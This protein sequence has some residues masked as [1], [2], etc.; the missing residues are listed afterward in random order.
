[1]KKKSTKV[2]IET[3]NPVCTKVR[4]GQMKEKKSMKVRITLIKKIHEGKN[5]EKNP[6][7]TKV[8]IGQMKE[9]SPQ[10]KKGAKVRIG[11]KKSPVCKK[12]NS[13][14]KENPR[15]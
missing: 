4:I 13:Q 12:N 15:R 14:K 11:W 10:M 2:R 6:I 5:W 3:K 7:C 9:N 8:R 1:M